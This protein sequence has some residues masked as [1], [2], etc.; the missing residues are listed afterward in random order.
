MG[1]GS[2]SIREGQRTEAMFPLGTVLLPTAFLPLN[3]FE[4][5]YRTMLVDLLEGSRLFGVVLIERGS[6]VG[7]GEVRTEVGTMARIVDAR[8]A[9]DSGWSVAVVG[10]QRI[11]VLRWLP[12]DPYPTAVV[13]DLPDVEEAVEDASVETTR[14]RDLV[15]RQ[16]RLLAHLSELGQSV[17]ASTFECSEDPALGTFQLAALGPFGPFDRQRLLTAT[18]VSDRLGLLDGYLGDL[19]AVVAHRMD[20][21]GGGAGTQG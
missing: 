5:R 6:E 8:P 17:T 14:F 20:G 3:V 15:A 16:R 12:D 11:Q 1:A 7:G 4:P 21:N 2:P 19:E 13:E 9:A 18:R 10:M